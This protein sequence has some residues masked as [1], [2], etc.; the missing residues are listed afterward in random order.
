MEKATEKMKQA[1]SRKK[2]RENWHYCEFGGRV[3][4]ETLPEAQRTQD[5]ESKT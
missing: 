5:I 4:K 1:G 3:R 2:E